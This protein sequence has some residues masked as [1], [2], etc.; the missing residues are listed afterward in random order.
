MGP[1]NTSGCPKIV[2][3][4]VWTV[5]IPTDPIYRPKKSILI[6]CDTDK[7]LC[8]FNNLVNVVDLEQKRKVVKF[9]EK[10][11]AGIQAMTFSKS[12]AI[13]FLATANHVH[14]CIQIDNVQ[15]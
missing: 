9:E 7:L 13:L 4:L 8:T 5:K 3:Q 15:I 12:G 2:S 11:A 10:N 14:V 1:L 6:H